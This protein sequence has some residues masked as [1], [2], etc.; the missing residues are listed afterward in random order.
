M[1]T[2]LY[3]LS[4]LLLILYSFTATAH[5]PSDSYLTLH[6]KNNPLQGQW[7]IA[8]RDLDYAI[9]LDHNGDGLITWGE[10]Q[11]RQDSISHYVFSRLT[12]STQKRNCDTRL[13]QLQTDEHSDGGYAVLQFDIDCPTTPEQ[14]VINYQLFF[15]LDPTHRGLL[16]IRHSE[17]SDSLIFTPE[18]PVREIELA[19]LS[20]WNSGYEY[21]RQGIWHICIGYDH[22]LFLI[23]LLLPAVLIW[24]GGQWQAAPELRPA[25]WQVFKLV[26]AFTLAHSITLAIATLGIFQL[27]SRWIESAI[28]ASVILA[29]ANNLR[30]LVQTRL[31]WFAFAFG[32]IH[33]FGFASVLQD[34]GLTQTGMIPALIGFNIGVELGQ[35]GLVGVFFPLA[36]SIR[37]TWFYPQI[38]LKSGSCVIALIATVWLLE[39]SQNLEL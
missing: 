28:A 1:K 7:D 14:L 35:L 30:P 19:T 20:I 3:A 17:Y 2:R 10:L 22:I 21:I 23:S 32:L 16:S 8:L 13:T 38:M 18:Q 27:P 36:Y 15:D 29:A 11:D 31:P 9:G 6:T 39:R 5:K 26:T 12:L 37:R 4:F 34:L 33:G 24:R 25:L